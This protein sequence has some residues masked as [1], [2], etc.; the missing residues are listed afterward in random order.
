VDEL[1]HVFGIFADVNGETH[2]EDVDIALR[3]RQLFKDNPPLR[4][5]DVDFYRPGREFHATMA[6][7]SAAVLVMRSSELFGQ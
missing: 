3:P 5:S 2:M 1:R 4:L 7:F 6:T